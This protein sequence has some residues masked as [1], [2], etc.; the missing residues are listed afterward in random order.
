MILIFQLL[1]GYVVDGV[2]GRVLPARV[3]Q[4]AAGVDVYGQL[5]ALP[6]Y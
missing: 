2:D 1:G 6:L 5:P 3:P 4:P